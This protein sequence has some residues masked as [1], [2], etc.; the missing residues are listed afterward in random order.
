[1]PTLPTCKVSFKCNAKILDRPR[2]PVLDTWRGA[3]LD[4]QAGRQIFIG[5]FGGSDEAHPST[6]PGV[7]LS[8]KIVTGANP[9]Y[10]AFPA[11][12]QIFYPSEKSPKSL[13]YDPVFKVETV[14]GRE[15]WCK[16]HYRCTPR[17][18]DADISADRVALCGDENIGGGNGRGSSAGAWTLTTLDNG[19]IS[20]ESWT[21]VDAADD[22]S[23]AIF[24]YS[25]AAAAAG[26]S[27]QGALLCSADG[28]W[29]D[30]AREGPEFERIASGFAKCGLQLW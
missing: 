26:Q 12:H 24:Y 29:P 9:A 1:M 10:D 8:W 4:T 11:Q 3:P 19:V 22:L 6:Q 2:V 28:E 15:I 16:R 13:W 30:G 14:D 27:Y 7:P 17:P 25:G 20:K 23:W 18:V 21:T 5:H